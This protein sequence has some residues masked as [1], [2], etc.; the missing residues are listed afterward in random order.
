M[1]FKKLTN[2]LLALLFLSTSIPVS[3][4]GLY[5]IYSSTNTLTNQAISQLDA[6]VNS[7]GQKLTN[8]LDI[9]SSEVRFLK[10]VPPI[11]GIIRARENGGIDKDD[12]STYDA[13]VNRL[14]I[15][16]VG[17]MKEKNYYL[18]LRFL[19]ENGTEI[20]RVDN[21]ND[22]LKV[23]AKKDME[24]HKNKDFFQETLNIDVKD[25]YISTISLKRTKNGEIEHPYIPV[26]RC[27]IAINNVN[28]QKR[29]IILADVS[30]EIL[31]KKIEEAN[32]GE[33]RKLFLVDEKG[34]YLFNPD[35]QKQWGKDLNTQEKLSLYYPQE[36][37]EKILSRK[38]GN[39]SE[40]T[41]SII[42]YYSPTANND[43]III[44]QSPKE[45]IFSSIAAF[46][47][48]TGLII[49]L[50]LGGALALGIWLLSR[51]T[52]NINKAVTIIASSSMQIMGTTEQQSRIASQ[53]AISVNETS[54][55][56]DEL[57]VSSQQ[58][59]QQTQAASV[60]AQ[61]AL[62]LTE[63]GNHAVDLSLKGMS[64]LQTKVS[65]IADKIFQLNEQT[66]Q[67]SNISNLVSNLA[68]QTNMLALNAAVEAVRAGENGKGFGVIA[69]EIRK[70][71][72]D[73]KN[74]ANKI[75]I[76]VTDIQN[77]IQSTVTVTQEGTQTLQEGIQIN[78]KTAD[79][80][81]G[82]ANAVNNMVLN[83]QQISLNI[84]Q[85]A[86]AIQEVVKRMNNLNQGAQE[87]SSGINQTNIGI[88]K[89]NDGAQTLKSII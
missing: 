69:T 55:T 9:I 18:K 70:L 2:K 57:G 17:I 8:F 88:Q 14:N 47:N 3:I 10:T 44:G 35:K 76:L 6:E 49:I 74:S 60:A 15:I 63:E 48:V 82:V 71:S 38:A 86:N 4:V 87:T 27:A 32:K 30:A 42:S 78:Q 11:Q 62:N 58:S 51:I 33:E 84:K 23:I 59:A 28:G 24:N 50:S 80:F 12:S 85:Q 13:W 81:L 52:E 29:G 46:R 66:N 21:L 26:I 75:T 68:N 41:N 77:A 54:A 20:V 45:V 5:G 36:I 22:S 61:Q 39:I 53:Q 83:N 25:T 43:L 64:K 67:I 65:G 7:Q 73:S 89:L 79:V 19:D 16:F 56:M 72:D 31:L 1:F 40:N 34:Y 37:V